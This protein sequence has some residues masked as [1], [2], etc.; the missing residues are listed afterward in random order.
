MKKKSLEISIYID[1]AARGNPGPAGAGIILKDTKKTVREIHKYLGEATNNVAEYSAAILGLE[2][3]IALG[4]KNAV[5]HMDS[6]LVSQQLKGEYRVRDENMKVLFEK[7]IRLINSFD[8]VKIV[9][10][11]RENNKEADKLANKAINLSGLG[12]A[13]KIII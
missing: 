1:G 12:A 6:E 7:A 8:S 4:Y 10:I 2:E 5:L 13:S 11:D 3:A 9:K